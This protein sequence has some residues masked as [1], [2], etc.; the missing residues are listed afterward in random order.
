MKR[1]CG[2]LVVSHG[3]WKKGDCA[4]DFSTLS[5][6]S[7]TP[8]TPVNYAVQPLIPFNSLSW[9]FW[10]ESSIDILEI[11]EDKVMKSIT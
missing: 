9:E 3:R 5:T 7:H 8:I 2:V 4:G 1:T 6:F 10:H 11:E